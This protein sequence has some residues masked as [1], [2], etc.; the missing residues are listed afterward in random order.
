MTTVHFVEQLDNI[1]V[2]EN[3]ATKFGCKIYIQANSSEGDYFM[4]KNN[5]VI[6]HIFWDLE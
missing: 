5:N 6:R 3:L 1:L 2:A 4:K